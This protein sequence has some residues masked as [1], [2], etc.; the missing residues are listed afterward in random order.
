M[1]KISIIIVNYNCEEWLDKLFDSIKSQ[2]YKNFE[3]I[4]IDNDSTDNSVALIEKDYQD[5]KLYRSENVGFGNAVNVASQYATGEFLLI[6]N[7]DCYLEDN[8]LQQIVNEY[9]NIPDKDTFGTLGT[10]SYDYDKQLRYKGFYYGGTIDIMTIGCYAK[11]DEKIIFNCGSP[12]LIRKEVYLKVGGFCPNIFLY[13]ED[14]DLGLRLTL[15]GYKH[16]FCDSTQ[17]YHYVG[18]ATGEYSPQKLEWYLVGELNTILN[19]F[20]ILL[21]ISLPVHTGFFIALLLF[22]LFSGK[23][24]FVKA[25]L[26]GYGNIFTHFGEILRFRRIVQDNRKIS[27]FGIMKR[28]HYGLGRLGI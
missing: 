4:V 14:V 6:L 24:K 28:M 19:N 5:V 15:Y 12:L 3:I 2:T 20:S 13:N 7:T 22:Y 18:A 27:D 21:F 26:R 23:L 10:I 8:F 9:E 1:Y 25:I 11:N 16:Y 17:I